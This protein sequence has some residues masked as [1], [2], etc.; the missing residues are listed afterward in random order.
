MANLDK[1]ALINKKQWKKE[2]GLK[3][4]ATFGHRI[5]F[6]L[7]LIYIS[8]LENHRKAGVGKSP[9]QSFLFI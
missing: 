7:V 8:T 5:T 2:I 1:S 6:N 4:I 9:N 3:I